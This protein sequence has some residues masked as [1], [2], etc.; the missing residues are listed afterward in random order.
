MEIGHIVDRINLSV[1]PS[2]TY[3]MKGLEAKLRGLDIMGKY[4]QL[5]TEHPHVAALVIKVLAN[6]NKVVIINGY[7]ISSFDSEYELGDMIGWF[8]DFDISVVE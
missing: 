5:D 7:V 3:D 6:M 1:A 2:L 4:V 8:K